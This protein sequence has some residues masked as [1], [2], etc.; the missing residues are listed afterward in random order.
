MCPQGAL[1]NW[2]SAES[3]KRCGLDFTAA[4]APQPVEVVAPEAAQD[5]EATQYCAPAEGGYHPPSPPVQKSTGLAVASLILAILSFL[6]L[7]LLG[8]GAVAAFVMG[9]MALRKAQKMPKLYGG[10]AFAIAGIV[11][12][13]ISTLMFVYVAIIAAIAIPNLLAAR[14]AA[15]EAGVIVSLRRVA[16]AQATFIST[17]GAGR[18]YATLQELADEGL[19]EPS[20][21]KS[22][23][24]G[25]RFELRLDKGSYEVVATPLT[26]G[27]ASSPGRRSFYLSSA[28]VVRAA[29]RKGL[30]ASASDPP[31]VQEEDVYTRSGRRSLD[32]PDYA[33]EY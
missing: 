12:S 19:I 9:V 2:A 10:E 26:Y 29:D 18:R 30:A 21:A 17:L 23:K 20:L 3:C 11:L 4:A 22:V 33:P 25:Y 1:V 5:T 31:I 14:R 15:N 27:R 24:Y 8:V 32:N 6:T 13:S 7:G 16:G 28:G